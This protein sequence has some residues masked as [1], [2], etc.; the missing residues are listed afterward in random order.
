MRLASWLLLGAGVVVLSGCRGRLQATGETPTG[1]GSALVPAA[2]KPH[3]VGSDPLP[4]RS[5]EGLGRPAQGAPG[6]KAKP[7]DL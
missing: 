6:Q 5:V 4:R 7:D 3:F 1:A 2:A